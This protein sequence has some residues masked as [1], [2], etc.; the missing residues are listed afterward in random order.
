MA[1]EEGWGATNGVE[2][3]VANGVSIPN[4][5]KH[6]LVIWTGDGRLRALTS[7]ICAVNICLLLVA[8]LNAAGQRVV[9]DG[10]DSY[11]QDTS[12][13]ET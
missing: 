7:Q 1:I 2:Y 5:G 6:N 12:W 10:A 4:I 11:I 9:L 3:E 13:V 8:R